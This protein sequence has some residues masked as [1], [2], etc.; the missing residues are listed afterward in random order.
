VQSLAGQ[1]LIATPKLRDPNFFR[2]VVLIVQHDETNGGMGLILNRPTEVTVKQAWKEVA[3]DQ[4]CEIDSPLYQGG[5][6]EGPMMVLHD[7]EDLGQITVIA[8]VH[9]STDKDSIEELVLDVNDS[10]RF[11]V[12]YSGWSLGQLEGEIEEGA[13]LLMPAVPAH[14][15]DDPEDLWPRL[16]RLQAF[17]QQHPWVDPKLIPPDPDV[18]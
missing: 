2:S 18:N 8:G 11:F 16:Q 14:V 6:C 9:F 3:E 7:R 17:T 1:L 10:A 12:G 4:E 15:Y 13:W 5:P